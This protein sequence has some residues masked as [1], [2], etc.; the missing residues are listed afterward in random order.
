MEHNVILQAID[1][2]GNIHTWKY[3]TIKKYLVNENH[4]HGNEFWKFHKGIVNGVE[5]EYSDSNN[6]RNIWDFQTYCRQNV[7]RKHINASV[8]QD[9]LDKFLLGELKGKQ[10]SNYTAIQNGVKDLNSQYIDGSCGACEYRPLHI[11]GYDF[12]GKKVKIEWI[13]EDADVCQGIV[14]RTQIFNR[15]KELIAQGKYFIGEEEIKPRI[16]FYEDNNQ[17][18]GQ[19]NIMDFMGV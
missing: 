11:S 17:L 15:I 13:N 7:D 12:F 2:K 14:S 19:M 4:I 10:K 5:L 18:Q 1:D 8:T 9:I 6:M 3:Y 16:M